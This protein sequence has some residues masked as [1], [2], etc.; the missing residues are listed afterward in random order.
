MSNK[1]TFKKLQKGLKKNNPTPQEVAAQRPRSNKPW[2]K[3]TVETDGDNIFVSEN[4]FSGAIEM[5]A[6][7]TGLIQSIA[8]PK[9]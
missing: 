8:Q 4:T 2:R 7:L 9:K 1:S 6:V 3:I 5:V